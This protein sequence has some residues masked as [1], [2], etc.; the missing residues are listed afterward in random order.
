MIAVAVRGVGEHRPNTADTHGSLIE[1]PFE[2]IPLSAG[3]H[4]GTLHQRE[5]SLVTERPGGLHLCCVK[6][7]ECLVA[8]A[9]M[10]D[11][12]GRLQDAFEDR[13]LRG[14]DTGMC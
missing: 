6:F 12:V 5:S 4:V 2:V 10:P 8:E 1:D 14:N 7:G 11:R 3:E 9:L 13:A